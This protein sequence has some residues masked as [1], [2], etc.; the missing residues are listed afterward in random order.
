M[1]PG[2]TQLVIFSWNGKLARYVKAGQHDKLVELSKKY[3]Q[4]GR[5][6]NP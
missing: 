1:A 5:S 2:S 6:Y 4:K 3:N